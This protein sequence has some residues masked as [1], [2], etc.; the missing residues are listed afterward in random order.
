MLTA[1]EEQPKASK[2]QPRIFLTVYPMAILQ[3]QRPRIIPGTPAI[4]T[5]PGHHA[6]W[7]VPGHHAIRI[8]LKKIDQWFQCLLGC[9]SAAGSIETI[10]QF[11]QRS[12]NNFSTQGMQ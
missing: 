8:T 10:D 7:K 3:T 4:R 1:A 12:Q 5:M 2:Q 9:A 11:F 6:I